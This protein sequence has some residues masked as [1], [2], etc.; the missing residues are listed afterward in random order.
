MLQ[1]LHSPAVIESPLKMT[2]FIINSTLL[3]DKAFHNPQIYSLLVEQTKKKEESDRLKFG[4]TF[5]DHLLKLT[6]S[7]QYTSAIVTMILSF[8]LDNQSLIRL[9]QW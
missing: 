7:K 8:S 5:I 3:D 4:S 1:S 6:P 9:L 2:N